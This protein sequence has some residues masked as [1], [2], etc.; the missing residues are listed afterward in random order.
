MSALVLLNL[1]KL[2]GEKGIAGLQ[3]YGGP[4]SLSH[5]FKIWA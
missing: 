1:L 3:I 2:F 5:D 4:G